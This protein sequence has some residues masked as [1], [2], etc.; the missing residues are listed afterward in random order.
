[1]A[2]AHD[3]ELRGYGDWKRVAKADA[4]QAWI[5]SLKDQVGSARV[6]MLVDRLIHGNPEFFRNLPEDV[7]EL[8]ID[9]EPGLRGFTT[10]SGVINSCYFFQEALNQLSQ[11]T[12]PGPLSLTA[13]S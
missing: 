11:K 3:P 5:H 6:L 12:S 2:S 4:C 13:H 7:T 9:M 10:P 8:K 1:M